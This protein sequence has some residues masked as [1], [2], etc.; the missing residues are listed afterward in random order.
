M[1]ISKERLEEMAFAGDER[2]E[3]AR[4]I[5]ELQ[6]QEP[7]AWQFNW[8][9]EGWRQCKNKQEYDEIITNGNKN[10]EVRILYA[11]PVPTAASQPASEDIARDAL[12]YRF[13]RDKDAFGAD[14]EPGLASWD[15][16]VEL[17]YNEFDAAIDDRIAH[18][19]IDYVKL[20]SALRKHEVRHCKDK[21]CN[22]PIIGYSVDGLC[23]DC[24]VDVSRQPASQPPAVPD[25]MPPNL[26]DLIASHAD[27]LF[28][29]DDVQEIWNACRAAMLQSQP[30][31]KPDTLPENKPCTDAPE[32]IWLQT[33]GEWPAGGVVGDMTWCDDRQHPDDTLYIRAD[34][35][36]NHEPS[37]N[38]GELNNG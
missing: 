27:A 23:E 34:L 28:G 31:S 1:N 3:M 13:L 5:L 8:H 19:D 10:F 11:A 2:A 4:Y 33:A 32:K 26:R 24:Y 25:E 29:D 18:P 37:G 30:V 38:S 35:S 17:G 6:K 36:G 21:N 22:A 20:D 12:R 16:L 9:K 15:D 14:N 7:V